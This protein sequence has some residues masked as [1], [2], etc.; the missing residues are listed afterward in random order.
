MREALENK[1]RDIMGVMEGVLTSSDHLMLAELLQEMVEEACA[2]DEP[3]AVVQ[4]ASIEAMSDILD[5]K[6]AQ[7]LRPVKKTVRRPA[8]VTPKKKKAAKA[9]R[10][11]R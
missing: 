8:T 4:V 5:A 10:K 11:S 2:H 7:I 3:I 9:R 1:S 6:L